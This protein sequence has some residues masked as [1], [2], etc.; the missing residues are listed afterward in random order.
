MVAMVC[1]DD[2]VYTAVDGSLTIQR[3]HGLTPN[4]NQLGGR[5][6]VRDAGGNMVDFDQ[7]LNDLFSRYELEHA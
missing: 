5:W 1:S 2:R 4:G 6:V 3:E 7:Y